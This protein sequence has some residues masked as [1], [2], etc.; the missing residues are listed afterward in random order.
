MEKLQHSGQIS[1]KDEQNLIYKADSFPSK[2]ITD[3]EKDAR[4]YNKMKSCTDSHTLAAITEWLGDQSE[5]ENLA[6]NIKVV[7][8]VCAL[9]SERCALLASLCVAELC[10]RNT[11][12]LLIFVTNIS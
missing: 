5:V 9:V 2:F 4:N 11:K 6:D 3:I 12:V 8:Y 7:Q 1:L 10:N